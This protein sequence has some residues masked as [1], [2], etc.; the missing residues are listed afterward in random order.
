MKQE[1]AEQWVAALR[2]GQY[3]QGTG[4]L[5]NMNNEFC[6]LGVLCDLH[7][8]ANGG[9]VQIDSGGYMGATGYL[10][11]DVVSWAGMSTRDGSVGGNSLSAMNDS[12]VA[13]PDIA[14]LISSHWQQ[15]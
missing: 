8:K 15:L 11:L 12:K 3:R 13:F 6:V 14:N 7:S 1:I 5:C 2:S 4:R 10:P 9:A